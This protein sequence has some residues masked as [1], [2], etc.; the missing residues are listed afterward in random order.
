MNGVNN[1]YFLQLEVSCL[2]FSRLMILQSRKI[3]FI[4]KLNCLLNLI[5]T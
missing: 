3:Y 5:I 2:T 4:L 1:S